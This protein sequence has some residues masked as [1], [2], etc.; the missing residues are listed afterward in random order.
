MENLINSLLGGQTEINAYTI[1]SILVF[2]IIF[3]GIMS[4]IGEIVRAVRGG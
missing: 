3:D 4:C 1:V 2:T